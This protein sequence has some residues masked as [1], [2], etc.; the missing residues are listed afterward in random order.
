MR[1]AVRSHFVTFNSPLEGVLPFMYTDSAPSDANPSGN[2]TT[3]MG[4]LLPTPE[5]ATELPWKNPDGSPADAASVMAAWQVVHDG[6]FNSSSGAGPLTSIRLDAAGI[7]AATNLAMARFEPTLR[8]QFPTY[9]SLNAYAQLAIWSM[10]WAMGAGF[11]V[12]DGFTHFGAAIDAGNFAAA[13]APTVYGAT[14]PAGQSLGHWVGAGNAPRIAATDQLWLWAQ[15]VAEVGG[16]P[17]LLSIGWSKLSNG[18]LQ[19]TGGPGFFG[20]LPM[21][22]I[23]ALVAGAGWVFRDSWLPYARAGWHIIRKAVTS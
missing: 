8:E 12:A 22:P 14:N 10:A 5:S 23:V 21:F 6:P 7:Q 4:Y 17:D 19:L 13:A 20:R 9:D 3:A 11:R 1:S 15:Q 2:V 16:D 18:A